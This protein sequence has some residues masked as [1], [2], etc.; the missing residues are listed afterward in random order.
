MENRDM[1]N[2]NAANFRR[3]LN[4]RRKLIGLTYAELAQ[5]AGLSPR[6]VQRALSD[7]IENSH[8][9]FESITSLAE[10]LGFVPY[11]EKE[12]ANAIRRRQAEAKAERLVGLVQGSSA[13]EA[14]GLDAWAIQ[15]MR[16]RTVRDLLA[17]S[18][19]MLWAQ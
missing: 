8:I 13:L 18:N 12:D 7:G 14:Q 2:T 11:C 5:R 17:G 15:E 6:T 16:E 10:V 1:N 9:E 19:R 4:E 3:R